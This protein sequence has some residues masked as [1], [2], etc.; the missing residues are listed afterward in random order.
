MVI[1][2]I[3]RVTSTRL[4]VYANVRDKNNLRIIAKTEY[5]YRFLPSFAPVI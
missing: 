1:A 2:Y 5:A 4:P 3:R